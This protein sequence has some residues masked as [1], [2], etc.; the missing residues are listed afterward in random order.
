MLREMCAARVVCFAGGRVGEVRSCDDVLCSTLWMDAWDGSINWVSLSGKTE[1][2][3][4]YQL[5][6]SELIVIDVSLKYTSGWHLYKFHTDFAS[7]SLY[8]AR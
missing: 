8:N 7:T 3:L 1:A 6:H 2:M 5:Y 4:Y